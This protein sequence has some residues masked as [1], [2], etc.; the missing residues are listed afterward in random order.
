MN[1]FEQRIIAGLEKAKNEVSR[2]AEWKLEHF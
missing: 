1:E 2:K